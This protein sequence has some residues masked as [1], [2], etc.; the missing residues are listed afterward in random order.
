[1][2]ARSQLRHRPTLVGIAITC[3]SFILIYCGLLSQIVVQTACF[4]LW[5]RFS[6][7]GTIAATVAAT[8]ATPQQ[9]GGGE[10]K[11]SA[12]VQRVVETFDQFI[13]HARVSKA[14]RWNALRQLTP[15]LRVLQWVSLDLGWERPA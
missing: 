14:V 8:L 4:L 9:I 1:M 10:Y 3:D 2:E 5:K 6:S 13:R 7:V 12:P 11:S 15:R